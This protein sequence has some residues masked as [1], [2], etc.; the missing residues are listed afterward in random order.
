[1]FYSPYNPTSGQNLPERLRQ[2]LPGLTT[3]RR[4][5][6]ILKWLIPMSLVLLV[7]AYE[8]GPSR[9]VYESWGFYYHL[10]AEILLFGTVGPLLAFVLLELIGRWIDEK[11]TADLQS[12]LLEKAGEKELETRQLNDDTL[13]VLFATSLLITTI[14]SDS[15]GIPSNTV[16]QIEVTEQALD[17][18]I[19]RLRSHL[20]S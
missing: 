4:Q 1:M 19:Q 8:L 13:Q 10:L 3:F 16:A 11:E 5:L 2:H 15:S 17:E 7:L 18:T 20:V 14:K 6:R 12:N 9:W